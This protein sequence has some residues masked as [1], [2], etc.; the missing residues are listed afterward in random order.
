M[1]MKALKFL[2]I[3]LLLSHSIS[4]WAADE[5][6]LREDYPGVKPIEI[7]SLYDQRSEVIIFDVRSAY[8][9][10]T[11]HIKGA[12]HLALSDKKFVDTLRKLRK[13]EKRPLI[14][15]CNGH[16]C[17]KSYKAVKMALSRGLDKVYAYDAGVFDWAKAYP[18]ETILLG[19]SSAKSGEMI[20]KEKF[21][22]HM[23]E[24]GAFALR[25][26]DDAIT[27]DIRDRMQ[28]GSSKLF[29]TRQRSVPLD[30]D[31][32]KSHVDK[33]KRLKKTLLIYDA[34]G[35]QV[36]WLQYYLE[37]TGITD[38]YFMRG[39]VRAFL[40][41]GRKRSQGIRILQTYPIQT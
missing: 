4:L 20:S 11:I 10:D 18:Q 21:E 40:E 8:E 16:T 23:M 6:P 15:Y 13:T 29:P 30:N 41:P 22:A 36:R 24:P 25:V 34:V 1:L 27:L 32:L 9:Y 26:G 7:K 37:S 12:R 3:P 2:L 28:V 17:K 33:A 38:Y 35:K 5:F 14:F 19:D 39:G 31:R